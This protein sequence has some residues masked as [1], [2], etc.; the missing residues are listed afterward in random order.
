MNISS[1]NCAAPVDT[2]APQG[3]IMAQKGLGQ[4][5]QNGQDALQLIQGAS[6]PLPQ[7]GHKL[8]VYA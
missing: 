2:S 8:S 7:A 1:S 3:I 5:K 4:I 6:A